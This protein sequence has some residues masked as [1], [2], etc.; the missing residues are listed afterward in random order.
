[1]PV[2]FA[3]LVNLFEKRREG[4][5]GKVLHDDVRLVSF[6]P[7]AV[8]INPSGTVPVDLASRM[9]DCLKTWTGTDW[10][11]S[12]SSETGEDSL[13]QQEMAA[14]QARMEE[15][16]GDPLVRKVLETFPG[17]RVVSVVDHNDNRGDDRG[18]D[19]AAPDPNEP[20][21]EPA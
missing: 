3:A 5:I 12:I 21:D 16:H 1:M 6:R 15:V 11:I 13:R 14:E 9:R 7:G 8:A 19:G 10:V 4:V 17:A 2:T 20:N 18:D